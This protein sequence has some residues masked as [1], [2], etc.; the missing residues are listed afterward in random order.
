MSSIAASFAPQAPARRRAQSASRPVSRV[1]RARGASAPRLQITRWGRLVATALVFCLVLAVAAV[2][3]LGLD[4]PAAIASWDQGQAYQSV[5]VAPG[6]TLWGFAQQYAPAGT[7][8]RDFMIEIQHANHLPSGSLTAGTQL[9]I[10]V[11][12]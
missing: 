2:L 1:S 8:P 7:D 3:L 5:T 10:P 12:G 9:D 11:E 6:D 4:A